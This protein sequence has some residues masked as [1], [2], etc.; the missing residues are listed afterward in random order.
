LVTCPNC[1]RRNSTDNAY[2]ANCGARL[3]TVAAR[4][5]GVAY[6]RTEQ[7]EPH[8]AG[9][10]GLLAFG[11]VLLAGL[12]FAVGAVA[13]LM[14]PRAGATSTP[15]VGA[16]VPTSSL[17]IFEQETPSP[18]PQASVT[19]LPSFVL[20]TQPPA[21]SF[22][23]FIPPSAIPGTPTPTPIPTP[24][25]TPRPPT[26]VPT[27]VNCAGADGSDVR[28]VFLG[29]GNAQSI[30]PITRAW[31]IHRVTFR[32]YLN[33]PGRA[34]LLE[35]G[36]RLAA[37]LCAAEECDPENTRTFSPPHLT[38]AGSTLT[39]EFTCIDNPGTPVIDECTTPPDG[40]STVQ[41]D[42]EVIPGT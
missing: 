10:Q 24:T 20:F 26:P 25:R 37:D 7:A 4:G 2:C 14:S 19:P 6:R 42:Y 30:G 3:P 21:L 5:A 12:L 15:F 18:S 11:A 39:F 34:R 16:V 32:P 29:F 27:P 23:P 35:N 17:A 38:P 13:L 1:G 33:E 40:G 31:C 8:G 28:T 22:T 41:I 9:G 36:D